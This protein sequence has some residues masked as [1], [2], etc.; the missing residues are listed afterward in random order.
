MDAPTGKVTFM[1]TDIEDNVKLAQENKDIIHDMFLKHNE[2]LKSSIESNNGFVFLVTGDAFCCSFE[3][4]DD[5]VTASVEI[6]KR[7]SA[8]KWN[9]E[10]ELK[11]RIGIHS[12]YAEWNQKGYMGYITLARSQRVMS[13]A[14]GGQ[15]LLSNEAMNGISGVI[16]EKISFRDLGERRLKD[17]IQSVKLF[18]PIA[19][20]LESDFPPL[21]TLD[22]RPNNI[23]VQLT[24]FIGREKEISTVKNTLSENRLLTLLGS[25]GTGKTRLAL[26]AGADL[27]DEFQNGVWFADLASMQDGSLLVMKML[28]IFGITEQQGKNPNEALS[29]F[30]K[31]KEMLLILDNCEHMINDCA[32]LSE[33]LLQYAPKLKIL[34]TSREALR[35]TGE[36]LHHV[37]PLNFPDPKEQKSPEQLTQYEAVRLFIERALSVNQKFRVNNENASSLAGICYQLDGIPLA[38]ELAAA[39][40]NILSLDKIYDKLKDRFKLLTG[41]NRTSLPRQQTL[42]AMID[43]SYNLLNENEKILFERLAVFSGGWTLDSAENICSDEKLESFEVID[44]LT[45]LL[46]KSLVISKES[47]GE[48]RFN[49]LV[50]IREYSLNKLS[51]DTEIYSRHF[52]YFKKMCDITESFKNGKEQLEYINQLETEKDN[53]RSAIK[54]GKENRTEDTYTLVNDLTEFWNIKGYFSEGYQTCLSILEKENEVSKLSRGKI[55]YSAALMIYGIGNYKE[56]EEYAEKSL[57]I[58]KEENY[59]YGMAK[60]YDLLGIIYNINSTDFEKIEDYHSKAFTIF[61]ELNERGEAASVI[62]NQSFVIHRKGDIKS[63]IEKKTEA[64]NIFKE[65]KDTHKTYLVQ[66]S[67][68]VIYSRLN[69]FEKAKS[70]SEESLSLAYLTGDKYM[71]SINLVSLACIYLG[72]KNFEKALELINDGIQIISDCGYIMSYIPAL[73]HKGEIMTELGNYTEAVNSFRESVEKGFSAGIEFFLINNFCGLGTAYFKMKDYRNSYKYFTF[74]KNLSDNF[75]KTISKNKID[76]ADGLEEELAETGI[77]ESCKTDRDKWMSMSIKEMIKDT[78]GNHK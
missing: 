55:Y 23:P 35:S 48:M 56:Q 32:I 20:G 69:E 78:T 25:G 7:I 29:D 63:A 39:R 53:I 36:T 38:I 60:C 46:D 51:G 27:I 54:W 42:S 11:V 15:I 50:T 24:S 71:I 34:A 17:L 8:E 62:L 28:D 73:F 59:L 4:P 37:L 58:F 75:G 57:S 16:R 1:F 2:I 12:G 26:Q 67:L 30:L 45:G 19:E 14:N 9:N 13:A 76:F 22:A 47:S 18:Q 31:S 21:K 6:Q 41:G 5:A 3:K 74:M 44:Y 40:V 43:W 49:M 72:L 10:T 65:L 33:K 66:S 64:L 68:G 77:P 61:S 70:Y 52:E